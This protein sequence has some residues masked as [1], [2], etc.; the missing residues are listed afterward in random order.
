MQYLYT[1]V[2]RCMTIINQVFIRCWLSC[3]F[4]DARCFHV[5]QKGIGINSISLSIHSL[6]MKD[7][8]FDKTDYDISSLLMSRQLTRLCFVYCV[9]LKS[10]VKDFDAFDCTLL[11][12]RRN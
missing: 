2:M 1:T 10:D 8:N 7:D 3:G 4:Y 11:E 12:H 6:L 9:W 5:W